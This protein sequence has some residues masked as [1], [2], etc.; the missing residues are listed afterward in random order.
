MYLCSSKGRG[1]HSSLTHTPPS[2]TG[3][4]TQPRTQLMCTCLLRPCSSIHASAGTARH[5]PLGTTASLNILCCPSPVSGHTCSLQAPPLLFAPYSPP[6]PDAIPAMRLLGERH[7]P[8]GPTCSLQNPYPKGGASAV[9]YPFPTQHAG[10][11]DSTMGISAHAFL[12]F[13]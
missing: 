6:G 5:E 4:S 2:P 7:P 10:L 1:F 12:Y 13:V 8:L 11:P 9:K 3:S